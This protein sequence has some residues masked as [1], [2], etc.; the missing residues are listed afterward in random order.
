MTWEGDDYRFAKL[1]E[2]PFHVE[3]NHGDT[4]VTSSYSMI[5]PEGLMIGTIQSFEQPEG[6][7]YYSILIQL[8][9]DFKSISFVDIVDNLNIQEIKLLEKETL[10]NEGIN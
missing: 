9:V 2:I 10:E 1:E 7:N 6:E 5:F 8:S 3:L 4:I